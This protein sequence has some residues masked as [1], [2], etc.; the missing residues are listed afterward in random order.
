MITLEARRASGPAAALDVP[1][2]VGRVVVGQFFAGADVARRADPDRVADDLGIAVRPACVVDEPRDVAPDR[3]VAH[4]EPIQLEA[5]DVPRFQVARLALQALAV[6]DLLPRVVDDTLVLGN[7]L[8]REHA[9]P[10]NLRTPFLDHRRMWKSE[11]WECGNL[12][13]QIS[14]SPDVHITSRCRGNRRESVPL[15]S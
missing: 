8:R 12:D 9:P 5:P 1:V 7:G 13:Y 11:I 2:A 4:V 14:T 6:G 15:A 10:G 3:R